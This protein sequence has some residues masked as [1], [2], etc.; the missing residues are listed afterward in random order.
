MKRI[1]ILGGGQLGRMLSLAGYPLGM[2]LRIFEPASAAP[3]GMLAPQVM[4]EYED[5]AALRQFAAGLDLVSYEFENVP[6]AA[7]TLLQQWLPVLPGPQALATAQDRLVEKQ[8]FQQRGIPTAP[9]CA[10]EDYASLI[11]ALQQLGLPA[12]LKTRRFGYDGK[13]QV[14]I[15]TMGEATQAWNQLAGVPLILE[16][17]VAFQRELSLLAVRAADGSCAFYPLVENLHRDGILRRSLAPAPAVSVALQAEA[18]ALGRVALEALEYVGVLAIELFDTGHLVVNEMAPR[19][20]NSGH[21]TIE[22]AEISQF[23]NHLRA[24]AGLPLGSPTVRGAAAMVNLI[25]QLPDLQAILR[26]PYTH[27]HLYDKAPRAG[28]KLGHVTVCAPDQVRL[29]HVVAQVEQLVAAAA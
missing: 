2:Y 22:G 23:E 21:W 4:A 7:A 17:F 18:E 27:L 28:R 12:V 10:V 16:G 19:V 26:L 29:L 9:F 13:G 24:I 25:G 5:Q 8:F 15:R 20:H 11:A 3:A 1:G 14:L 6:L